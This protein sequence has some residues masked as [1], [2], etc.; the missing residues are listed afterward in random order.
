MNDKDKNVKGE[1]KMKVVALYFNE[2]DH[3]LPDW[4]G[5]FATIPR[6]GEYIELSRLN[7]EKTYHVVTDIM[8]CQMENDNKN[9]E[10]PHI[11]VQI[12]VAVVPN[13]DINQYESTAKIDS[14][15]NEVKEGE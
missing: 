4:V 5:K 14:R 8:H 15:A 3:R 12:N 7:G 9:A 2:N 10:N 13:D 6:I 11:C 1:S